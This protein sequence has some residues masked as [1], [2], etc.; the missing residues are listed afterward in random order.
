MIIFSGKFPNSFKR[1]V[2]NEDFFYHSKRNLYISLNA[3]K[4]RLL[5][6]EPYLPWSIG[7]CGSHG[8]G[9][10]NTPLKSSKFY[11][12]H[13]YRAFVFGQKRSSCF[14]NIKLPITL[15]KQTEIHFDVFSSSLLGSHCINGIA[16][17]AS[18]SVLDCATTYFPLNGVFA[19]EFLARATS[20]YKPYWCLPACLPACLPVV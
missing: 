15:W 16:G 12:Q 11:T 10:L 2:Q 14:I 7:L 17:F 9:A 5:R 4:K 1:H 8:E 3:N 20:L 6:S 13:L 18:L 19:K